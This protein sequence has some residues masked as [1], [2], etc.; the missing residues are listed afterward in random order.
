MITPSS[1]E[2]DFAQIGPP[3]GSRFPE[4]ILP[5]QNGRSVELHAARAGRRALVL[6]HRS[7]AW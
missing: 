3:I 5:D 7:A 1:P 6:F 2:L 4:V